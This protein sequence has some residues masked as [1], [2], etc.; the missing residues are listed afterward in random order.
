MAFNLIRQNITMT[1]K[2]FI[3]FTRKRVTVQGS[4]ASTV[5]KPI[6]LDCLKTIKQ[7]PKNRKVFRLVPILTILYI[8]YVI[9]YFI[10]KSHNMYI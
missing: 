5:Y 9:M 8:L 1:G 4:A 2:I 10:Q 6:R 7:I 3:Y